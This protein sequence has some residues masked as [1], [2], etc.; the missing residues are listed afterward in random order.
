LSFDSVDSARARLIRTRRGTWIDESLLPAARRECLDTLRE[1]AREAVGED[2]YLPAWF[3]DVSESVDF[4]A[5]VF[6]S[7]WFEQ[8]PPEPV[9]R[10][11]V[12]KEKDE[13][14]EILHSQG[15]FE[16]LNLDQCLDFVRFIAES[17]RS[18]LAPQEGYSHVLK[19]M[20][21]GIGDAMDAAIG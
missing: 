7:E 19:G 8:N 6:R 14:I 16:G 13:T 21:G 1:A 2:T 11:P 10:D 9:P 18:R 15:G 17:I 3:S 20:D 4:R 5:D 12:R